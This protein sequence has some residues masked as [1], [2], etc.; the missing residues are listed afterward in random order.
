MLRFESPDNR[1][2]TFRPISLT[3]AGWTLGDPPGLWS[4]YRLT[5][6][7]VV[8][9]SQNSCSRR[10]VYIVEGEKAVE[11]AVSIGLLA[12]TSA[13]GAQSPHKT[14][15]SPIADFECVILPDHDEGG[16]QYSQ[17][18]TGLLHKLSPQPHVKVVPLPGLSDHGDIV[19]YIEAR[20]TAG[21]TDEKIR[22]KIEQL[23]EEAL[24]VEPEYEPGSPVI[25]RLADVQPRHIEW[26]W[27][28]RIALGKLTLIVGDPGLGKSTLSLDIA[29]RVSTGTP[30]PDA[31]G[32][33]NST[34]SVV[35]L[36]AEDEIDDTI[37]PRLDAAGADVSRIFALESVKKRLPDSDQIHDA[38]FCLETDLAALE[39]TIRRTGHVRLVVID[40]I[41]AYTGKT[42]SHKNAEVRRLLAPLKALAE[43]YQVAI[44]MVSHL[45]KDTNK[46]A[47]YRVTGSLAFAAAA[48]AVWAVVPDDNDKKRLLFLPI[49]NNLA[50]S[51]RQG[52]AFSIVKA[53]PL[54]IGCVR[55][56]PDPVEIT[57]Q[58]AFSGTG[59]SRSKDHNDNDN[60]ALDE[61]KQWLQEVLAD[62]P[63]PAEEILVRAK[64]D[65]IA[66][67]TLDRAKKDSGVLSGKEGSG[68]WSW[69]IPALTLLRKM[70]TSSQEQPNQILSSDPCPSTQ[71]EKSSPG[72]DPQDS[73]GTQTD[74]AKGSPDDRPQTAPEP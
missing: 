19:D 6:L 35:L 15:W 1:E 69:N 46:D 28:G 11:A 10:R 58:E 27:Q 53:T 74:T 45:N 16:E 17:S 40:P 22:M 55:W 13:H 32:E 41:S 39:T 68:P 20:R 24:P 33:P 43:R 44:V 73:H 18:V 52:L 23:A 36:S 57:A 42:D 61:A 37:R 2:K 31:P 60:S 56:E 5:D 14:D 47:I 72:D 66:K 59:A 30:W 34:G 50:T 4:L 62:G 12:T 67:R 51:D 64:Q 54:D 9:G 38:T 8:N 21:D 70:K 3:A 26:L 25:V 63:V 71:P 65:G 29:S 49:K 7:S 48:R